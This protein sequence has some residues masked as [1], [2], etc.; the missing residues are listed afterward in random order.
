[1]RAAGVGLALLGRVI[2]AI[3][4]AVFLIIALGI[5]LTLLGANPTN[6]IVKIFTGIANFLAGP[7]N[8]LFKVGD[9]KVT[10]AVN[11]GIAA[12][13]YLA[14]GAVIAGAFRRVGR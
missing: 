12:V 6:V 10:T 8:G 13:V 14:I 9:Q 4:V 1:M 7:F 11:W 2:L 5:L 3:A